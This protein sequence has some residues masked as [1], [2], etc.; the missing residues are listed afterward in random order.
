MQ[1]HD[2]TREQ[3]EAVI[4]GLVV[5]VDS[6]NDAAADEDRGRSND[7]I[8]LTLWDDGSGRIGRRSW[9]ESNQ[10]EDWHEFN[11][12]DELIQKL[13]DEGLEIAEGGM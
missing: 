12:L 6:W 10:V 7:A 11:N 1:E 9:F 8:C 2:L 3:L 5:I 13:R 4:E